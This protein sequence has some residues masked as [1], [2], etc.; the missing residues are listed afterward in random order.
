M[1][2]N[3]IIFMDFA[4]RFYNF[5][6][7]KIKNSRII[8]YIKIISILNVTTVLEALKKMLSSAASI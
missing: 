4:G 1:V 3:K 8:N 2:I 5:K 7:D 6:S